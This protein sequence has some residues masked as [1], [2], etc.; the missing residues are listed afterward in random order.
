MAVTKTLNEVKLSVT[1]K[2]SNEKSAGTQT[3]S[4]CNPNATNDGFLAAGKAILTLTGL[5]SNGIKKVS[6]YTVTEGE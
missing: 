1:M 3:I 2:D 6:N 4:K 5:Q